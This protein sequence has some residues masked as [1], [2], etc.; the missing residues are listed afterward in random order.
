MASLSLIKP[1]VLFF[2]G[3][4]P[5]VQ[6]NYSRLCAQ[7]SVLV[8]SRDHVGFWDWTQ[9]SHGQG[10]LLTCCAIAQA[11]HLTSF[12]YQFPQTKCEEEYQL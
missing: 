12:E 10:K 6:R 9:V 8:G 1:L 7:K 5:E 4:H 3:P 11:Y 2:F